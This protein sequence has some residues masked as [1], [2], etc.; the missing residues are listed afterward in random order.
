M[1]KSKLDNAY[2]GCIVHENNEGDIVFEEVKKEGSQFFNIT[3]LLKGL[4]GQSE[5][6]LG[7]SVGSEI[8]PDAEEI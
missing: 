6:N 2:K 4:V 7:V 1:A 8:Q 5:V 3:K